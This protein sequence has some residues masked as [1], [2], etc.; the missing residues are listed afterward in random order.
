MV[1]RD[2]G[3]IKFDPK[4][5]RTKSEFA[6]ACD[7]NKIVARFKKTGLAEHVNQHPPQF[8][9]VS[10]VPDYRTALQNVLD[11][12]ELFYHLPA[13]TREEFKNDP[14]EFLDFAA[15]PENDDALREMGVLPT[16]VEKSVSE[17]TS[18]SQPLGA[19]SGAAASASGE[20][21][22]ESASES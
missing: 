4:E 13:A 10:N 22:S 17:G 3:G 18:G 7:I 6:K 20:E 21:T 1:D 19:P 11:V 9:D 5:N 16:V 2:R 14:A 15:N 12:H 8:I